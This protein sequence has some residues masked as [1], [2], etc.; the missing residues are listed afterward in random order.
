MDKEKWT[1]DSQ[2][3]MRDNTQRNDMDSEKMEVL[4]VRRWFSPYL[5]IHSTKLF[6]SGVILLVLTFLDSDSFSDMGGMN[7]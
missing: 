6:P 3:M 4:I 7:H 2:I 5:E 1:Q